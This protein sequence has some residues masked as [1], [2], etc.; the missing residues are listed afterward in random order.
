M[1]RDQSTCRSGAASALHGTL[2]KTNDRVIAA[3]A[4]SV[5]TRDH[6]QGSAGAG[7]RP[8]I[9]V[10]VHVLDR[11][12]GVDHGIGQLCQTAKAQLAARNHDLTSGG[13]DVVAR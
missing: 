5:A 7:N 11:E 2:S 13:E 8:S 12:S 4:S 1:R 10:A 6:H 3:M 9:P